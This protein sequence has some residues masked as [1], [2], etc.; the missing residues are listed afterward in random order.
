MGEDYFGSHL[1]LEFTG[2]DKTFPVELFIDLVENQ[3]KDLSQICSV[4]MSQLSSN[5]T[6]PAGLWKASNIECYG[7]QPGTDFRFWNSMK[8]SLLST[9]GSREPYSVQSQLDFV[10]SLLKKDSEK[11]F[12]R[13]LGKAFLTIV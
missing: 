2:L 5:P 10:Q 4:A 7:D 9:F 1:Q 3:T 11:M 8:E 12:K 6:T 13:T